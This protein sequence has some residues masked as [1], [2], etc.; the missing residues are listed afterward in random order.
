MEKEREEDVIG[1]IRLIRANVR[2]LFAIIGVCA[3]LLLTRILLPSVATTSTEL[4]RRV[5]CK[6]NQQSRFQCVFL[7]LSRGRCQ[8]M[9]YFMH[10]LNANWTSK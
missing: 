9:G 2:Y 3:E 10:K 5:Q 4:S 1:Y 7:S 6:H 8:L